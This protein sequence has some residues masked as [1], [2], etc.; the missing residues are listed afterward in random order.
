MSVH[1]LSL[2][3]QLIVAFASNLLQSNTSNKILVSNTE[4]NSNYIFEKIKKG[5]DTFITT[6]TGECFSLQRKPGDDIFILSDYENKQHFGFR[7]KI[8]Q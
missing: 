5:S 6:N 2:N 1:K 3:R 4:E 8:E 7:K